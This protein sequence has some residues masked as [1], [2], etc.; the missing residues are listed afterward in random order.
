MHT[1]TQSHTHTRPMCKSHEK[2]DPVRSDSN[3]YDANLSEDGKPS[4][5][6]TKMASFYTIKP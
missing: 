6:S 3:A 1:H 4:T 5:N 2:P